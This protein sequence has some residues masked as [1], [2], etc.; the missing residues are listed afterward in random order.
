MKPTPYE[1]VNLL[2]Q[3][4]NKNAQDI[5]GNNLI[6][7]YLM[8]SLSYGDFI[9]ERSDIDLS[10]VVKE[11][12]SEDKMNQ[13]EKLHLKLEQ[14]HTLWTKR[15]ECQYVPLEMFKN[16]L[17][18]DLRRPYYGAGKFYSEALYGNEWLINNYLLYK[19]GVSLIGPEF[20]TLIKPIDMKD[21]QKASARDLFKEWVPK[22]GNAEFFKDSHYQSYL[23]L[24]LCR[25]LY[26]VIY[27]EVASKVVS[28]NWVK[29]EY[30]Q[31]KNLIETAEKWKYGDTM[32][33]QKEAEEFVKATIDKVKE[34]QL[35]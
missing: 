24:N 5:L 4:F 31:W 13:I 14:R 35:I 21:V 1:D 32:D 3:E 16:L 19:C 20:K 26:T 2:L 34:K 29:K 15:I 25:I 17:P 7:I 22:L 10:V 27:G 33:M 18:V 30:P 23:V 28:A 12:I 9:P 6:G 8:G 11:P